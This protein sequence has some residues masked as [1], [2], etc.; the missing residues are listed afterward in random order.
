[1]A[2]AVG[3]GQEL[4]GEDALIDLDALLLRLFQLGLRIHQCLAGREAR[5]D[6]SGFV[7]QALDAHELAPVVGQLVVERAGVPAQEGKARLAGGLLARVAAPIG[8][9][10]SDVRC[11]IVTS[12]RCR[13]DRVHGGGI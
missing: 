9:E 7:D 5:H 13:N 4:V 1:M 3:V 2:A 11:E 10:G 12:G 6:G 8:G